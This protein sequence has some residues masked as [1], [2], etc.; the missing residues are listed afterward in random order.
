MAFSAVPAAAA[1]G[2]K[3]YL[4]LDGISGESKDKNYENW[5]SLED[6]DFEVANNS[7]VGNATSGAGAGKAGAGKAVQKDFVIKK[8]FDTS[9]IPLF[10]DMVMGNVITRGQIVFVKVG[11]PAPFITIDL[12]TVAVVDY[13]FSDTDEKIKLNYGAINLKYT[14]LGPDGKPAKTI[15]GG[16][17]FLTNQKK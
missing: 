15:T 7:T 8:H 10:L 12:D 6:V 2:Y 5:I 14:I 16:W 1:D 3:V 9:T 11:N 4:K 13:A 17:D